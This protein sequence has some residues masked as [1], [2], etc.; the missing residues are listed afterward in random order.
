M[1]PRTIAVFPTS[2]DPLMLPRPPAGLSFK[3][4]VA[5]GSAEEDW[6]KGFL[7]G[8]AIVKYKL[9]PSFG[10][11]AAQNTES[12]LLHSDLGRILPGSGASHLLITH[13]SSIA[14]QRFCKETGLGLISTPLRQQRL[15]ED[16]L[17]FDHYLKSHA[18]PVPEGRKVLYRGPQSLGVSGKLVIQEPGSFGS[19]GTYIISKPSQLGPLEQGGCLKRGRYYL[20]RRFVP[21]PAYGITVFVSP[22][23][24]ALSALRRQCFAPKNDSASPSFIGVQWVPSSAIPPRAAAKMESLFI[25]L[26]K[27]LYHSRFFGFANI[28]FIL[29]NEIEVLVLE[30]NPRLSS[31]TPQLIGFPELISGLPVGRFFLEGGARADFSRKAR[32]FGLPNSS[33]SGSLLDIN[34]EGQSLCASRVRPSGFYRAGRAG[35]EFAGPDV[36]RL[37]HS[38]TPGL[39]FATQAAA[40][41]VLPPGTLAGSVV[42]NFALFNAAGNL[43]V[44][45]LKVKS[46]FALVDDRQASKNK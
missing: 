41:E 34:V 40:G 25:R 13:R 30:C 24:V 28:D 15:F 11:L 26:G 33:F 4:L 6:V 46:W 20:V 18:L 31:A 9:D 37:L 14:I 16:K 38:P 5:R 29:H 3:Y 32:V 21:G 23:V 2:L 10:P 35:F 43:N 12:V 36:R 45:G 42:T 44:R 22:G 8:Q 7:P 39:I 19:S 1:K 17:W 27:L